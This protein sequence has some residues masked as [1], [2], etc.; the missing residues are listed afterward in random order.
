ML[1]EA[2]GDT[3]WNERQLSSKAA[4]LRGIFGYDGRVFPGVDP[5]FVLMS[6]RPPQGMDTVHWPEWMAP[7]GVPHWM[8]L[9]VNQ[10][11]LKPTR[12]DPQGNPTRR[13][14]RLRVDTLLAAPVFVPREERA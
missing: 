11:L 10:E 9:P 12:C 2:K 5:H 4:R 6:P 3:S 14:T 13:G 8:P 7:S 1:I